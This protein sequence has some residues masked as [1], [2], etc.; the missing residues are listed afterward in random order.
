MDLLLFSAVVCFCAMGVWLAA[1]TGGLLAP[2]RLAVEPSTWKEQFL[3]QQ[4]QVLS[5]QIG[6]MTL[7]AE[8][9]ADQQQT[10]QLLMKQK[11]RLEFDLWKR[12][13]WRKP[14]YECPYC[15]VSVHSLW[16]RLVFNARAASMNQHQI[17][18]W[19]LLIAIPV[20]SAFVYIVNKMLK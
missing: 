4:L 14:L 2:V 20:A 13:F 10:V 1:Q 16:V 3:E 12:R 11:Q 5:S 8:P 19:E 17:E 7:I 9:T 18:L 6:A 15:M